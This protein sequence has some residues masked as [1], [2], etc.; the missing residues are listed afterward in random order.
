MSFKRHLDLLGSLWSNLELFGTISSH[1][2]PFQAIWSYLGQFG[3]YF[4]LGP[5]LGLLRRSLLHRL[6]TQTLPNATPPIGQIHSFSKMAVTFER[7]KG[8]RKVLIIMTQSVFIT[9]SAK[10]HRL[11][12]VAL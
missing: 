3:V 10:S 9:G 8:F 7:L 11:G 4:L 1:F 5:E 12:V 6:Q 2:K